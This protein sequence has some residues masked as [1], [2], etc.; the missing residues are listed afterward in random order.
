MAALT[1]DRLAAAS[2][3][4]E[5]VVLRAQAPVDPQTVLAAERALI[6]AQFGGSRVRYVA[7]L[8]ASHLT[9][10]DARSIVADR[11][12]RERIEERFRPP[13]A[14]AREIADFEST[15]ATTQVRLV[16][17][18]TEAPWLGDAYRGFAVQ[19]IAPDEVFSLPLGRRRAIDTIDG[20]FRVRALGPS[21]PLYALPPAKQAIVARHVLGRFARD[22]VYARWLRSRENA[23]LAQAICLRDELPAPGDVDLTA[24]APYLGA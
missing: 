6:R 15:Y 5:R 2:A 4:L 14:T 11:I 16:A 18:D 9:L 24:W 13:A 1:G 22:D 8:R 3:L 10:A 19:T 20:R 23:L 17:V 12:G 7:A 21:L